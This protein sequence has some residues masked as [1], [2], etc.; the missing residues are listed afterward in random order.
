MTSVLLSVQPVKRAGFGNAEDFHSFA[1]LHNTLHFP[2]LYVGVNL[3]GYLS[4]LSDKAP[5]NKS[6]VVERR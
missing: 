4:G 5:L 3:C 1:L 2:S 6:G